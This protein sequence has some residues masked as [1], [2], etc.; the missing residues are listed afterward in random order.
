MVSPLLY[1]DLCDAFVTIVYPR[2]GHFGFKISQYARSGRLFSVNRTSYK[3]NR[4]PKETMMLPALRHIL[5]ASAWIIRYFAVGDQPWGNPRAS[6]SLCIPCT[7]GCCCQS[8]SL[9]LKVSSRQPDPMII[10]SMGS[11]ELAF[12]R[13]V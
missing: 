8:D 3:I 10:R 5:I 13:S 1:N 4:V 9:P 2:T 6:K 7:T 11:G 12:K